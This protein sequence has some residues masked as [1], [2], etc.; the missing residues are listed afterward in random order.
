MTKTFFTTP[1]NYD[2]SHWDVRKLITFGDIFA[3]SKFDKNISNWRLDSFD[4]YAEIKEWTK[5]DVNQSN[6]V[7]MLKEYMYGRIYEK[8]KNGDYTGNY[9]IPNKSYPYSAIY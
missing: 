5:R 6:I 3:D 8:D 7:E 9:E 1:F 4:T 2:L